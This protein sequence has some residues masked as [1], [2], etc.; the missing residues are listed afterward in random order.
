[1]RKDTYIKTPQR[2]L[3]LIIMS[4]CGLIG[5]GVIWHKIYEKDKEFRPYIQNGNPN[6][7]SPT[8][9]TNSITNHIIYGGKK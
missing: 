2:N 8:V 9:I 1:M 5:F 6:S 3:D 7:Y 4:V